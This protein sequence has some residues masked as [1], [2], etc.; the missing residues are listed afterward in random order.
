M[1]LLNYKQLSLHLRWVGLQA[2][3]RKIKDKTIDSCLSLRQHELKQISARSLS[4]V[5]SG[6][7]WFIVCVCVCVCVTY[8]GGGVMIKMVDILL[9]EGVG[10]RQQEKVSVS[11]RMLFFF[12]LAR[13]LPLCAAQ[14]SLVLLCVCVAAEKLFR[15]SSSRVCVSVHPS[16]PDLSPYCILIYVP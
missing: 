6:Y 16:R 4:N 13:S 3:K 14:V 15:Y 1:F 9:S 8:E 7:P 12:G 2:E 11:T 5:S 10:R